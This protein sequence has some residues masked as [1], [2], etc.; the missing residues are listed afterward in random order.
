LNGFF[1]WSLLATSS[2]PRGQSQGFGLV[3]YG[4]QRRYR[5]LCYG[6]Y[7]DTIAAVRR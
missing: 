5:K 7:G 3:D 4:M 2:G 1:T 6:S